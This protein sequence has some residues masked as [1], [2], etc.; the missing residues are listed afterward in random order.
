MFAAS[1]LFVLPNAALATRA[2]GVAVRAI[3][4]IKTT[5]IKG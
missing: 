3:S 4:P 5:T 2:G 1:L